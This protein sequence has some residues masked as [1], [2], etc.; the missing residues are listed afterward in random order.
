MKT[1]IIFKNVMM[2]AFVALFMNL[3]TACGGDDDDDI[4]GP[5]T[6]V[7]D[8]NAKPNTNFEYFVPFTKWGGTVAEADGYMKDSG[9]T[10]LFSLDYSSEWRCSNPN[11]AV[12]YNF[13]NGKLY[14]SE[15]NYKWYDKKDLDYLVA[16][17]QK[18]YNVQLKNTLAT[19]ESIMYAG[20][21][22]VNGDQ[23]SV[24]VDAFPA[25]KNMMVSL[26]VM[27]MT[28]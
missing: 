9:F 11:I 21:M 26:H 28:H 17:T 4:P 1:M 20:V 2:V 13:E 23:V 18:K 12:V 22:T 7:I 10:N 6:E 15:V 24:T 5:N 19:G 8:P 3:V 16:Q 25:S 14:S 27:G